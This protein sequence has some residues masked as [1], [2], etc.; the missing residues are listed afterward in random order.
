M[1][2]TSAHRLTS[3]IIGD[4]W[5]ASRPH[6]KPAELTCAKISDRLNAL[7]RLFNRAIAFVCFATSDAAALLT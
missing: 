1:T 3:Q 2:N 6:R 7:T 5:R 4:R